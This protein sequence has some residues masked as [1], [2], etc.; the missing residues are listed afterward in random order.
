VADLLVDTNGTL[1]AFMAEQKMGFWKK[2]TPP[3]NPTL[4]L[5]NYHLHGTNG[6]DQG[7]FYMVSQ[8]VLWRV[9]WI[10]GYLHGIGT[11]L[12]GKFFCKGDKDMRK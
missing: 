9:H 6:T 10:Y 2:K 8:R 4:N 7:T 12:L 5:K 3:R 1:Y 11:R